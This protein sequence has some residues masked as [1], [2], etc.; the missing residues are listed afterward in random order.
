MTGRKALAAF[1]VTAL[2]LCWVTGGG[3]LSAEDRGGGRRRKGNLAD[4]QANRLFKQAQ[5]YIENKAYARGV[6]MMKTIIDQYPESFVKYR[7]Y[8]ALGKHY[9]DIRQYNDALW[10]LRQIEELHSEAA[11]DGKK[12]AAA[13]DEEEKPQLTGEALDIYLES[14][15]LVGVAYF[16]MRQYSS[17]FPVLRRIT[18][19]YPNTI[20]ANQAYYYIGMSHF[21]QEHWK[22][23]IESLSLVGTFVD[24]DDDT[25][26][27]IEAGR[28]FYVKIEDTDLP[29]LHRLGRDIQVEVRSSSG[30][31][32]VITCIPLNREA[33]IFIGSVPTEIDSVTPEK[34]GDNVLQV[35]GGDEITTRY[36]DDNTFTGEHNVDRTSRTTVISSGKAGFT[37]GTF[38]GEA[39]AA[40]VG[41]QLFLKVEDADLDRTDDPD[42]VR[43]RVS[44]VYR[45]EIEPDATA[46]SIAGI[47]MESLLEEGED[48][49]Q[50]VERDAVELVLTEIPDPGEED[51]EGAPA[52]SRLRTGIFGG[53][54]E[55]VEAGGSQSA[56]QTDDLLACEVGDRVR[57]TY[58]DTLHIRGRNERTLTATLPVAGEFNDSVEASQDVVNDALEL[59]K[60]N[61]VEGEAY[62][63]LG[64]IFRDMGL[65]DKAGDRCHEAIKRFDEIIDVSEEDPIP[66]ESVQKAYQFKWQAQIVRGE[67]GAAMN[68]CEVFNKRYP[69]SPLVDDALK[70]MGRIFLEAKQYDQAKRVF[71]QILSLKNSHAKAEAQFLMAECTEAETLA[72][73][74]SGS[75][76]LEEGVT[77][78][79]MALSAAVPAYKKV[80]EQYPESAFAGKALA[81]VIDYYIETE[82]YA[83][84]THL[85]EKVFRDHQDEEWLANMLLKWVIVAYRQQ[86]YALCEQKCNE[87]IMNHPGSE[88]AG[89]AKNILP[90]IRKKLGKSSGGDGG[91]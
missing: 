10:P 48:S 88:A 47:S 69:T 61:L 55:V 67:L 14:L 41:A 70:E 3:R 15:Y 11:G 77:P 50:W 62:L 64:R 87:L 9:I 7:A 37:L 6:K 52:P 5:S 1:V 29:V 16:N 24:R 44:S 63:E 84:A 21:R 12:G 68:T 89:Q 82:D 13:A 75:K 31:S 8:L 86:N 22:K 79:R 74:H 57:L 2:T 32:E 49:E 42:D 45:E 59:A 34:I 4:F 66:M 19:D 71:N 35:L 25:M 91:A 28:R 18:R 39:S 72:A 20:W 85:L 81:K 73:V 33:D 78:E 83:T 46:H 17:A 26:K 54:V 56:D 38:D 40:F 30:D 43:V 60:M 90:G 27:Y 36:M 80:S 65:T 51:E 58:V 53:S 76:R 23:A